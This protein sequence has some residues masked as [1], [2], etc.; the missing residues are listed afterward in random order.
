M[1]FKKVAV[2]GAGT[3]GLGIAQVMAQSGY[4]VVLYEIDKAIA[5]KA[6]VKI[7]KLAARNIEKGKAPEG[8]DK[9]ILS[10]IKTT[11]NLQDVADCDLV[12]EAI[13]EN[14]EIKK[15]V[16]QQLD[17]TCKPETILASN[18]SSLSLTEIAA[19]TARPQQVVGMH[20]FNPAQVMQLVE[21]I[22]ALQTSEEVVQA[23]MEL[24]VKTGKK[25]IRVKEGP[26]FVVNRILIPGMNEAAFILQ[27]GLATVEDIDTAM[28][29]GANWPMGPFALCDLVGA[30]VTLAIC[31]TL[32]NE[33]GDPKYRASSVLKN[34]VRAG[35]LGKKTGRGFYNYNA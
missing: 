18:S 13:I 9:I 8:S 32:Y 25:P 21:V 12:I 33:T 27:E 22:P 14:M 23:I 29:L 2:L 28:K 11:A 34:Q 1:E 24:C 10:R 17:V 35:Y 5:D 30:D 6:V 19:A 26:G 15:K 3:M 7:G 31:D 16:Y 4:D 20:F